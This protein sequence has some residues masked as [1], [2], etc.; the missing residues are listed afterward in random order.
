MMDARR[1]EEKRNG[2]IP[3]IV[4]SNYQAPEMGSKHSISWNFIDKIYSKFV[5]TRPG[6]IIILAITIAIASFG[7]L[8]SYQLEQW[9]DPVWFLP[10]DTYL[11][12]YLDIRNKEFPE[13][14]QPA[15]V[16]LSEVDIP[17]NFPKI[18]D[19]VEDFRNLTY[20]ESVKSW[21]H[22]FADFVNVYYEKGIDIISLGY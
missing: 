19:L 1:I 4:H 22:D 7:G 20:I 14:G 13:R 21:P 11:S 5:L 3:C 2:A 8:G 17:S 16:F 12:D 6:K 15:Y 10:K 18:L 9:F